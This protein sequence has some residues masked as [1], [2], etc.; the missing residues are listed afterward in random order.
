MLYP[1]DQELDAMYVQGVQVSHYAGL[2]VVFQ[3]ALDAQ[4]S[5]SDPNA[6]VN[7]ILQTAPTSDTT[8][9]STATTPTN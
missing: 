3:A 7:A 9:L 6:S 2:R 4:Q 8:D 1:T 5:I